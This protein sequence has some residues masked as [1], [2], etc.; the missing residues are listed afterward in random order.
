MGSATAGSTGE[1]PYAL[2]GDRRRGWRRNSYPSRLMRI[3]AIAMTPPNQGVWFALPGFADGPPVASPEVQCFVEADRAGGSRPPT[4]AVLTSTPSCLQLPDHWLAP[5]ARSSR[6]LRDGY[7]R[8]CGADART[9]SG[10]CVAETWIRVRVHMRTRRRRRCVGPGPNRRRGISAL[11][12][13]RRC[14]DSAA[15]RRRARRSV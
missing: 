3:K 14:I 12:W 10:A 2:G 11:T 7:G 1:R 13:W 8:A 5:V 6:I 4:P 15:D 9:A